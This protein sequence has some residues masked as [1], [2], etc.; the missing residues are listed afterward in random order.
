MTEFFSKFIN[1]FQNFWPKIEKSLKKLHK[2]IKTSRFSSFPNFSL[3]KIFKK[4]WKMLQILKK[5]LDF[6]LDTKWDTEQY[7][8]LSQIPKSFAD[9]KSSISDTKMATLS[10]TFFYSSQVITPKMHFIACI[11][12]ETNKIFFLNSKQARLL[13]IIT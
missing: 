12:L 7:Q 5:I 4:N 10:V 11:I 8:I 1:F 13:H 6:F 9:T 3:M 2:K